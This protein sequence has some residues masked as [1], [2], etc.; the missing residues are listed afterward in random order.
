MKKL[1]MLYFRPPRNLLYQKQ[2]SGLS[3]LSR[4][5]FIADEM[6]LNLLLFRGASRKQG[7]GGGKQFEYE[8]K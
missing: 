8:E 1:F 5:F 6:I 4:N 3:F 2:L 7:D